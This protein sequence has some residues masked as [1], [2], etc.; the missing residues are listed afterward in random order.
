MKEERKEKIVRVTQ[1][2]QAGAQVYS[3]I[4]SRLRRLRTTLGATLRYAGRAAGADSP[5]GS[6]VLASA[7]SPE[8][9]TPAW[10]E[11]GPPTVSPDDC[12]RACLCG[13][14][15]SSPAKSNLARRWAGI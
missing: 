3:A 5:R 12:T 7:V 6:S 4:R 8:R 10:G 14:E 9:R 2:E 11:E 1:R 15:R 13:V